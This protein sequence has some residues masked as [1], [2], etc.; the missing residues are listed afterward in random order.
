[1]TPVTFVFVGSLVALL[2]SCGLWFV[3]F[4]RG[5]RI[6]AKRVR[7][8]SDR[9]LQSLE[10]RLQRLSFWCRHLVL[11]WGWRSLVHACLRSLLL[12]LSHLYDWLLTRF[13]RN[14]AATLALRKERKRWRQGR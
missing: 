9:L 10:Q 3:E 6:V 2:V 4:V 8:A 14:R 12:A 13:E 7:A 5:E 11:R 1:M